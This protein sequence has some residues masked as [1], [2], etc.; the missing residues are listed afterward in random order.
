MSFELDDFIAKRI[1]SINYI[2][3]K[4]HMRHLSMS[5]DIFVTGDT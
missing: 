5:P 3:L 2:S 1:V 4:I